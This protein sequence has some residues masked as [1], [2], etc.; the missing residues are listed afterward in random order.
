MF[1][2]ETDSIELGIARLVPNANEEWKA[3]SVFTHL[4]DLKGFP[5]R[6]GPMRNSDMHHGNWEEGRE[7]EKEFVGMNGNK[8]QR[9][10]NRWCTQWA[11]HGCTVEGREH[12][13]A[14]GGEASKDRG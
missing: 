2:F 12:V 9:C 5:E 13:D 7:I 6:I 8:N 3:Y 11:G 1:D 14:R 4:E 10:D